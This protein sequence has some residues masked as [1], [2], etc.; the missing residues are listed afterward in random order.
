MSSNHK[1]NAR[2]WEAAVDCINDVLNITVTI[3]IIVSVL[4]A[5]ARGEGSLQH[6]HS[7]VVG[8]DTAPP[9]GNT[10]EPCAFALSAAYRLVILTSAQPHH[11]A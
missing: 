10:L 4:C 3:T 6:H 7:V 5:R 1:V 2:Y 8:D 9:A 11:S